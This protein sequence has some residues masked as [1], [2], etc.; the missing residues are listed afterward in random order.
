MAPYRAER[1]GPRDPVDGA[2]RLSA[3]IP[4]NIAHSRELQQAFD[5][6]TPVLWKQQLA[7]VVAF[8]SFADGGLVAPDMVT[9][10]T[11][12]V[13][14]TRFDAKSYEGGVPE[15]DSGGLIGFLSQDL[16]YG[17]TDNLLAVASVRVP[18]VQALSGTT[19]R[20]PSGALGCGYEL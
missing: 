19:A 8:E 15:R 18:V 6:A 5:D 4:L 14:R 17:L 11:V 1:P 7:P 10:V 9:S 20:T 2:L 13:L 12:K 16:L 3:I